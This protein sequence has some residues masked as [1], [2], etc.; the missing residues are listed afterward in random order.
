MATEEGIVLS[1]TPTIARV[2]TKKSEAC[3]SCA[4]RKSCGVMGGGNDMEVDALNTAGARAGDRVVLKFQTAS[5]LKATF[6][7][8]VFPILCLLGGAIIGQQAGE[9]FSVD[10]SACS[11]VLG[12]AAFGLSILVVRIQGNAMGQKKDYQPSIIRIKQRPRQPETGLGD[13]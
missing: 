11:A 9:H 4:S 10:P 6:L 12:F 8:Y 7:L 2:K 13:P 3:E 1:A 5:L